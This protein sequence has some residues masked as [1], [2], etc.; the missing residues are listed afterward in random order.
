MRD[1]KSSGSSPTSEL[2]AV[3]SA[4]A[5]LATAA[6]A[7]FHRQGYTLYYG[8]AEAHLNM[9]RRLLDTR[10]PGYD[11]IGTVW[12]PLPHALM[13][14]FV[15]N[16]ALWRSGLAGVIPTVAAFVAAGVF[17]Y[18][19][20]RRISTTRSPW[21]A[22]AGTALFALN[23]NTL[24]LAS[25]PMT[26]SLLAAAILGS[27]VALM[28]LRDGAKGAGS[29]VACALAALAATLTRY[30]GWFLLPFLALAVWRYAGFRRM[31]L[32]ASIAGLGPLA[33]IAH[34]ANFY[35]NPLEFYNGPYSAQAI[36]GAGN[37]PGAH[38]WP[39][40]WLYFRAAVRQCAGGALYI[41]GGV[42]IVTVLIAGR[43]RMLAPLLLLS[44][45]PAFY[46]LSVHG[47]NAEIHVPGLWPFSF[48][49]TRYGLAAM[50]L[51]AFGAS[52]LVSLLGRDRKLTGAAL[53]GIFI[54]AGLLPW[55][56]PLSRDR[57]I[58]L[59][60]SRVNSEARR[61]WTHQGAAFFREHY[62]GG[63]IFAP[64]GDMSAIFREAGISL[65]E[66]VHDSNRVAWDAVLARP[67]LFLHEE[68][69]A[70][71]AGHP[72]DNAVRR[73][74][75]RYRLAHVIMVKD[76]PAINIYRRN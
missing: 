73:T 4:L 57:W 17:L 46:L 72:V 47:G 65:V 6:A 44:L 11:A 40:A 62:T 3:A 34:N 9:A 33:W 5:L 45:A 15:A 70:A 27:F 38:D 58:C 59:T 26:E 41:I 25:I 31:L 24:Y 75:A 8:D 20:L 42:G 13:L 30:E 12:L 7:W 53:A 29:T 60:E 56:T 51:L 61:A 36:A 21:P 2:A 28:R 68:W 43:R 18:S 48:Y 39:K 10:N 22:V 35:G 32:F 67:D 23:P 19:L 66:T 74:G 63:G 54:F 49:N 14:P 50:P 52:A 76:A 64:F 37:Y 16:D 71:F 55:L 1:S 69:A